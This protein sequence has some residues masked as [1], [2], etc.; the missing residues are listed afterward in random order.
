MIY[1]V[2][3]LISLLCGGNVYSVLCAKNIY[4]KDG[5]DS[6]LQMSKLRSREIKAPHHTYF[7]TMLYHPAFY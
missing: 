2:R 4:P 6:T 5:I 1:H 3:I 7:H